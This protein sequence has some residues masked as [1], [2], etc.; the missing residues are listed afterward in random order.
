MSDNEL[1]I[2]VKGK[3]DKSLTELAKE[4]KVSRNTIAALI[5]P[6]GGLPRDTKISTLDKLARVLG[7]RVNVTFEKIGN[8]A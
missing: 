7:Y 6:L 1:R 3:Q 2:L 5:S 4:A 8:D